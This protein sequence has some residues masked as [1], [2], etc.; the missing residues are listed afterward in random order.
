MASGTPS[1]SEELVGTTPVF[2][3]EGKEEPSLASAIRSIEVSDDALGMARCE[4]RF[5]NWGTPPGGGRP[6]FMFFDGGV[7]SFGKKLEVTMGGGQGARAVFTGR[8][9]AIEARFHAT[10]VPEIAVLADDLMQALRMTRR[11]ATYEDLSDADVAKR[12]AQAHGFRVEADAAGPTHKVLV[13]VAQSD[14]AFLRERAAA[15]DAQV[16]MEDDL[17]KFKARADRDGGDVKLELGSTITRFQVLADLAH[18][19]NTIHAHGY[20][21]SGKSDFDAEAQASLLAQEARGAKLGADVL[22][23]TL[24]ERKDHV[25]DRP[26]ASSD[27]ARGVAEAALKARGRAFVRCRGEGPGI[28][29]MKVGSRVAVAGAGPIFSGTY[30]ATQVTHRWD[31]TRGLQTAFEGE[32]PAVGAESGGGA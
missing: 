3:V 20:D 7:I 31:L 23:D 11:T 8:I 14:L 6:G 15:I 19:A 27:E 4:A 12:I 16:W 18:Q 30:V 17:L 5:E 21:R 25:V 22:K 9:T 13:Q 29:E 26:V 32:R 10:A 1:L 24:G 2:K 28:P